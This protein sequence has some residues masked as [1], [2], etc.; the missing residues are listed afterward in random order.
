[1]RLYGI[2][3]SCEC[4][5]VRYGATKD[6]LVFPD[7]CCCGGITRFFHSKKEAVEWK[8]KRLYEMKEGVE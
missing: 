5:V 2:C 1:M 3:L 6:A 4:V 8:R 7:N